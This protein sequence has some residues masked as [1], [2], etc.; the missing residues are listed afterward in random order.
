MIILLLPD[1]ETNRTI[2]ITHRPSIFIYDKG[3]T[4]KTDKNNLA[5]YV[6]MTSS[7]LSKNH[8]HK[9]VLFISSLDHINSVYRFLADI[10]GAF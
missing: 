4:G 3:K 9:A 5:A 8:L 2:A 1:K 10:A 7:Q 6:I